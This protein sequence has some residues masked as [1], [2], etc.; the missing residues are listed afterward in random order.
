MAANPKINT[1]VG[2]SAVTLFGEYRISR[3]DSTALS[4]CF[5]PTLINIAIAM[6]EE[7]IMNSKAIGR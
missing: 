4:S 1:Y 2:E 7:S 5:G 3:I 6:L